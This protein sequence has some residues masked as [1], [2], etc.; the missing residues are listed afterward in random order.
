MSSREPA[1]SGVRGKKD[2]GKSSAGDDLLRGPRTSADRNVGGQEPT[3]KLPDS[4]SMT[5][6][7]QIHTAARKEDMDSIISVS[8][9]DEDGVP[10]MVRRSKTRTSADVLDGPGSSS[11][12]GG[13][14][15]FNDDEHY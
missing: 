3:R 1:E 2:P 13:Q 14:E 9:P 10:A 4:H 15:L 11:N 7:A 6:R 12:G 8:I 5:T